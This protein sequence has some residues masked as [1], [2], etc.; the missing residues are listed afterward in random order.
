MRRWSF[1]WRKENHNNHNTLVISSYFTSA[2]NSRKDYEKIINEIGYDRYPELL[3]REKLPYLN[4]CLHEVLR[5]SVITPFGVPRKTIETKTLNGT[6]HK[7]LKQ[8]KFCL[9][10]EIYKEMKNI[11]KTPMNSILINGSMRTVKLLI[12]AVKKATYDSRQE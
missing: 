2:T 9:T 11:G 6:E 7:F 8:L 4:A 12:Q 10:F 3:D 1:Y 5:I